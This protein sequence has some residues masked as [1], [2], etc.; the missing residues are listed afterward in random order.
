MLLAQLILEMGD[1]ALDVGG[2]QVVL[3]LE[4]DVGDHLVGAEL[5]CQDALDADDARLP[6]CDVADGFGELGASAFADQQVVAFAGEENRNNGENRA[7]ADR[8]E[9]VDPRLAKLN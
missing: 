9:A 6:A 2:A 1:D 7:D 4:P 8:A 5:A 3:E